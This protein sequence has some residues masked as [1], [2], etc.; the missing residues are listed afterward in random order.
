MLTHRNIK[1]PQTHALTMLPTAVLY[2]WVTARDRVWWEVL[3]AVPMFIGE[4]ASG[5]VMQRALVDPLFIPHDIL[6]LCKHWIGKL[7][8]HTLMK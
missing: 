4:K 5:G 7:F 3:D 8:S 1:P 6:L 2:N